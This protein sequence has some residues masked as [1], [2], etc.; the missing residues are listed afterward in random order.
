MTLALHELQMCDAPWV[1]AK[2]PHSSR[3]ARA[4]A[5]TKARAFY[6]GCRSTVGPPGLVTT[7]TT[8]EVGIQCGGEERTTLRSV[9]KC[10]EYGIIFEVESGGE[11]NTEPSEAILDEDCGDWAMKYMEDG[12]LAFT[13]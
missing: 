8:G 5:R 3:S 2:H 9:D 1:Q 4:R 10:T 12:N 6:R 13:G 11:A 7:A